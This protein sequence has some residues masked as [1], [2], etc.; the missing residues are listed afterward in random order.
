MHAQLGKA[1]QSVGI[2]VQC[3][4]SS[5]HPGQPA[6]HA[7]PSL[8]TG[9]APGDVSTLQYWN[10]AL[11][12]SE[13]QE[14]APAPS[15]G[16]SSATSS[17]VVS[18]TEVSPL[19]DVSEVPSNGALE[20]DFGSP[21]DASLVDESPTT[22]SGAGLDVDELE[23]HA[24]HAMPTTTRTEANAL[25]MGSSSRAASRPPPRFSGAGVACSGP[26]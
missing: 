2:A 8:G 15:A 11:H 18:S 7:P 24:E 22:E 1:K 14:N 16:V 13:P 5:G 20:S 25:R 10:F 4:P 21:G 12:V 23:E 17:V 3:R 26:S 9:H 19:V 6:G